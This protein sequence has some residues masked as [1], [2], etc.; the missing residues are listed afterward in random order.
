MNATNYSNEAIY[1]SF[2]LGN[3]ELAVSAHELQ[4]VVNFPEEIVEV[5]L[6]PEYF[7]GMFSLRQS[8]IPVINMRALLNYRGQSEEDNVSRDCV[9]IIRVGQ[10]R[11]GLQ[12]DRTSEVL[13]IDPNQVS[14]FDY[15]GGEVTSN[16]PIQGVISL[17]EGQRLVQVL[18]PQSLINLPQIPLSSDPLADDAALV[19]HTPMCRRRCITFRSG[20]DRFGIEI[21]AVSEIIPMQ[22]LTPIGTLFTRQCLGQIELRGTQLPVLDFAQLLG[23]EAAVPDEDLSRIVL[24]KIDG[25]PLGLLVDSV[26]GIVE[27]FDD[28]MQSLPA[29]GGASNVILSGCI[30]DSVSDISVLNH[31]MLF[32]MPEV[33]APATAI[34]DSNNYARNAKNSAGKKGAITTYLVVNL[35][36][37]FVL[38]VAEVS[39][40]IDCPETV[41]AIPGAPE[42][43][44]GMFNLRE[45]VITVVSM[46]NLYGVGG[47]QSDME[48]KLLIV[49][50]DEWLIGL[51][52]DGVKDIVKIRSDNEYDTPRAMLDDWSQACNEDIS[53]NLIEN[54]RVLPLLPLSRILERVSP[55]TELLRGDVDAAA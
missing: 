17:D 31:D 45:K 22:Q 50:R 37:D 33:V 52:V 47:S 16:G 30:I 40:I 48:P 20:D 19:H 4:D 1:G 25:Q 24:V 23:R 8:I 29:F 51:R 54:N 34:H 42:F 27:F 28:D 5:P 2:C 53:K 9:A 39:E 15:A 12:F 26:D 21:G 46:R 14:L 7:T 55:T 13:R 6:A 41:N 3:L 49:E 35:G 10:N 32:A 18:N 43:I 11:L 38:P 36:F 44:D